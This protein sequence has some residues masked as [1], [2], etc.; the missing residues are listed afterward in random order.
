MYLQNKDTMRVSDQPK[1]QTP[2]NYNTTTTSLLH[3]TYA[4]LS[5][6]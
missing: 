5:I 2:H 4:K 6:Q 1:Y 3:V